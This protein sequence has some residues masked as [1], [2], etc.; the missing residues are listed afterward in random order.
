MSIYE[1]RLIASEMDIDPKKLN[2]KDLIGSIQTKEGSTPCFK[3][4]D[5]YCD[6]ADCLWKSDC[7]K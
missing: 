6:K 4:A 5:T 1:I 2:K 3:T 7:L